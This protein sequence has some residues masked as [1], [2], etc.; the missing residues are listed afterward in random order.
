M[1]G[2]PCVHSAPTHSWFTYETNWFHSGSQGPAASSW[3]SLVVYGM[4]RKITDFLF[5]FVFHWDWNLSLYPTPSS[6][7]WVSFFCL[8]S[9]RITGMHHHTHPTVHFCAIKICESGELPLLRACCR[10][11]CIYR[12]ETW[13]SVCQGWNRGLAGMGAW[14]T[15]KKYCASLR[16]TKV[17]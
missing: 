1:R 10:S 17:F 9:I 11:V 16:M 12:H 7:P 6:N 8:P 2:L 4:S 13:T 5:C 15:A 14:V 3:N